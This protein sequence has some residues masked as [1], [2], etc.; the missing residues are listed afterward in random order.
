MTLERDDIRLA[1]SETE[2]NLRIA[3]YL[4]VSDRITLMIR[5]KTIRL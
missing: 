5:S 3:I 2:P 4:I 1:H